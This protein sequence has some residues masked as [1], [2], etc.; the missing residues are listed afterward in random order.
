M[1]SGNYQNYIASVLKNFPLIPEL[2]QSFWIESLLTGSAYQNEFQNYSEKYL[3]TNPTVKDGWVRL[4]QKNDDTEV[5]V[6]YLQALKPWRK[7]PFE[8]AGIKIDAEWDSRQKWDRFARFLPDL[9]GKSVLDIGANCGYYLYRMFDTN[10]AK[11][12]GIDPHPLYFK[13][14]LA[15]DQWNSASNIQFLPI[16]YES[17]N[18]LQDTFDLIL[19]MGILYHEKNPLGCLNSIKEKLKPGGCLIV[20]SIVVDGPADYVLFPKDRYAK[21]KNVYF[22]PTIG[23]LESWI[24]KSGFVEIELI[25][26]STTDPSEQ[27]VTQWSSNASLEDFL[28]PTNLSR[29]IEGYPAPQRVIFKAKVK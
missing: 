25:S 18:D 17:L 15:L 14:F 1:Q 29:T 6:Q 8:I 21:M 24:K 22:I 16:G 20:E 23:A 27:R 7:G 10:A 2:V 9:T 5:L 26:T 19:L 4:G 13:Q 28:D 12:L 11:I 3:P